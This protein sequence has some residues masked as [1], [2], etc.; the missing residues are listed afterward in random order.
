MLDRNRRLKPRPE[1]FQDS[2]EQF[3]IIVTA[4]ERVFDQVLEGISHIFLS[5]RP[6]P[7]APGKQISKRKWKSTAAC[8]KLSVFQHICTLRP[9]E[10]SDIL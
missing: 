6:H 2:E 1:R 4:E 10:S 3:D 7:W 8:G 9:L 5:N